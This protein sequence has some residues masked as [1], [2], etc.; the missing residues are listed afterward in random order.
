MGGGLFT[1]DLFF[2]AH[3]SLRSSHCYFDDCAGV[4]SL[5]SVY[6]CH[7]LSD[8]C[9]WELDMGSWSCRACLVPAVCRKVC[10]WEVDVGFWSCRA[11]LVPAVCKT[12]RQALMSLL[13]GRLR[14]TEQQSLTLSQ[15][16]VKPKIASS[17]FFG[18]AGLSHW[19]FSHLKFGCFPWWVHCDGVVLPNAQCML[20][21]LV[22][23]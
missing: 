20:G 17:F 4:I 5:L 9:Y 21:V 10:Y 3:E 22:F 13:K 16:G 2:F 8:L 12:V 14:R 6:P 7:Q 23:S 19:D 18:Q 1:P 11:R 15:P